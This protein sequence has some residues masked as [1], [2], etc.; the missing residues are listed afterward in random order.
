L[1]EHGF[2]REKHNSGEHE[3]REKVFVLLHLLDLDLGFLEFV[4]LAENALQ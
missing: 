3:P 1:T 2:R 4:D